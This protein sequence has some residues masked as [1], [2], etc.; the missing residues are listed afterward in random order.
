M[1][2]DGPTDVGDVNLLTNEGLDCGCLHAQNCY[3][4]APSG[5][6]CNGE[7]PLSGG[8]GTPGEE[9]HEWQFAQVHDCPEGFDYEQVAN[10]WESHV[11]T[12]PATSAAGEPMV[13]ASV[14]VDA[15]RG[16][17]TAGMEWECD[18]ASGQALCSADANTAYTYCARR[19]DWYAVHQRVRR[20]V[21]RS[22]GSTA[23]PEL[24]AGADVPRTLAEPGA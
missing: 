7:P 23:V 19:A 11:C 9:V 22:T 12:P 8:N 20:A 5:E 1:D 24:R 21:S 18:Y 6:E 14:H 3:D 10:E 15:S 4:F 2:V 17:D 13:Q 16:E